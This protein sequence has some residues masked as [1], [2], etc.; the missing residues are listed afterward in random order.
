MP[1]DYISREAAL[2]KIGNISVGAGYECGAEKEE[3]IDVLMDIPAADVAPVVPSEWINGRCKA[4][5]TYSLDRSN[6]CPNCGA[7]MDLKE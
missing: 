5:W 4:C 2:S 6:Y 3:C 1:N 7:K